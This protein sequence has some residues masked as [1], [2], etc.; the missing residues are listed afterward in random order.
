MDADQI[1]ALRIA[2]GESQS[3]F[4]R[5]LAAT[6]HP[7][8]RPFTRGYISLLESGARL[9]TAEI[10]AALHILAAML[11]GQ[12]ELQ[13]RAHEATLLSTHPLPPH[14]LST[15]APRPCALPGCR[16]FYLRASPNQRYC[17]PDCRREAARRRAAHLP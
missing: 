1:K 8:R 10:T 3:R 11:D 13:A 16:L 4:G 9:P 6:I 12:T 5:A 2:R 14:T 7:R 17:S 15:I